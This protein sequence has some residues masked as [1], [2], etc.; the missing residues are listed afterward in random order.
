VI[1]RISSSQDF[2]SGKPFSEVVS[3]SRVTNFILVMSNL[4]SSS[5]YL[6]E[7]Y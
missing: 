5:G 2:G 4:I 6:S 1:K 7:I 3:I